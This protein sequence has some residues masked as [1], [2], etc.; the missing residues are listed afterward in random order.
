[1]DTAK[2]MARHL[3]S[4]F[5]KNVVFPA[6]AEYSYFYAN[7]RLKIFLYYSY[8][9]AYD[10]SVL[11]CIG[12]SITCVWFLDLSRV[13]MCRR[14]QVFSFCWLVSLFTERNNSIR[15]S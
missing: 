2:N 6:Q 11:E 5:Y 15:L 10:I 4:F 7:F 1:M 3:H 9:I 13:V 14:V 12:V 8:I